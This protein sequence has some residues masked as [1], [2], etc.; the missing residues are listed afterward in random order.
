[1]RWRLCIS[2][3]RE[4]AFPRGLKPSFPICA[5]G[6]AAKQAAEKLRMNGER[7]K[8]GGW[9]TISRASRI[10]PG[11]SWR[12]PFFALSEKLSFSAACKAAPFQNADLFRDSLEAGL[13][14]APLDVRHLGSRQLDRLAIV[15]G[16]YRGS[17]GL[18]EIGPH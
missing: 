17:L 9:K 11:A 5:S 13:G 1:M 2:P 18:I 16:H 15:A 6:G 10:V 4:A 14:R 8:I 7:A 3:Y 12:D